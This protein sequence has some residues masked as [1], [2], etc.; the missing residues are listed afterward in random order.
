[1]KHIF[2]LMIGMLIFTSCEDTIE[3]DLKDT[4]PRIVIDG[5]LNITSQTAQVIFS[6]SNGFYDNSGQARVSGARAVLQNGSGTTILL[7]ENETGIYSAENVGASPGESWTLEIESEG[8]VYTAMTT[9]PYP[10]T[11]D[12]LI[13]TVEE[14]PFGGE[15]EVRLFA[16]WED[17]GTVE[18]Y[19]RLRPF[20]NDT[21]IAQSYSLT[22]DAFSDGKRIRTPIMEEFGVGNL[23]KMQLLSVDENY[24]R[25]FLELS[26]VV[27][28]GF[29]GSNPY[30][31]VG[32]FDNGALGYFGIFSVSEKE[33]QL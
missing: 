21:L 11:L 28:N 20:L 25:Y 31:P 13:A 10:A 6:K 29:N 18:N 23:L 33:L 8:V 27:G 17:Q 14:R 7:D 3:L 2:I 24:Y 1:M 19:Y 22:N 16:E 15:T 9:A 5:T 32:N 12:T 26:S 4:T 30:N